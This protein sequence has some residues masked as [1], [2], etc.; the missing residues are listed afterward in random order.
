MFFDFALEELRE[1]CGARIIRMEHG[2]AGEGE[3][4]GGEIVAA[5][6]ERVELDGQVA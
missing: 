5:R 1:V 3:A 4:F 2:K 6:P